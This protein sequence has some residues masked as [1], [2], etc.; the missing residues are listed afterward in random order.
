MTRNISFYKRDNRWYADLPEV[1]E[2]GGTEAD[3]EMIAGAEIFLDHLSNNGD[4]IT[5]LVFDH[6][7]VVGKDHFSDRLMLIQLSGTGADYLDIR[8][9]Q[10]MWLCEVLHFVFGN[11]PINIYFKIIS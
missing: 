2:A 5:L 9:K 6:K 1:I 4:K 11:F 7:P 3:N 8:T 10:Q